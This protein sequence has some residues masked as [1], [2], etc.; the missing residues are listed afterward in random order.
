MDGRIGGQL[1]RRDQRAGLV[2]SLLMG[3]LAAG[4]GYAAYHRWQVRWG[5]TDLE[6]SEPLPGDELVEQ[7]WWAATRCVTIEADPAHV[8]PW[9]VQMGAYTRGGWYSYDRID[10]GGRPSAT[11]IVPELQQP[12]VGD[13]MP[14]SS[15]GSGFRVEA[16]DP[17]RSLMLVIRDRDATVSSVFVLRDAGP[18]RTRLVTRVRIGGR[19]APRALAFTIAMDV[20]DFVMFRRTLIGIRDRAERLS[21]GPAP[22]QGWAPAGEGSP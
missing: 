4:L 16:I 19:G 5:A 3:A 6:V 11:R 2:G 13:V 12:A 18:G 14:T 10:N 22:G 15:D 7:P 8:W 20:G 9:L 21:S 17:Q 1:T